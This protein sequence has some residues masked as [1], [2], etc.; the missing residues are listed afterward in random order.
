MPFSGVCDAQQT[1]CNA[2]IT[3]PSIDAYLIDEGW[4]YRPPFAP[5]E[6]TLFE[7]GTT[8]FRARLDGVPVS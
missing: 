4:F 5:G 2:T 1:S 3:L 6:Q 7:A 8:D